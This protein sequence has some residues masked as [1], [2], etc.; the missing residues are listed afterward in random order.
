M[1]FG[2]HSTALMTCFWCPYVTIMNIRRPIRH[3]LRTHK[4]QIKAA[5][6][7]H[8]HGLLDGARALEDSGQSLVSSFQKSAHKCCNPASAY[9]PT[10]EV[11]VLK[12]MFQEA[13]F[14]NGLFL[15]KHWCGLSTSS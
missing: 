3:R 7:A 5:H 9:F 13:E 6:E 15:F 11:S 2:G 10:E 12:P 14:F 1:N 4:P 8:G